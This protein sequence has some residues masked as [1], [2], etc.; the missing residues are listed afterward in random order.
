MADSD[1]ELDDYYPDDDDDMVGLSFDETDGTD[2]SPVSSF[3]HSAKDGII[4]NVTDFDNIADTAKN[5]LP[6]EYSGALSDLQDATD[7]VK[8]LYDTVNKSMEPLADQLA[9]KAE[10]FLP[11]IEK[12]VPEALQ[13][14]IKARAEEGRNRKS[15]ASMEGSADQLAIDSALNEIFQNQAESAA[16]SA[17]VTT[18]ATEEQVKEAKLGRLETANLMGFTNELLGRI[19]GYQDNVTNKFQRKSM[20]LKYKH[21]HA[22]RDLLEVSKVSFG[23]IETRLDAIAKNTALPD[24]LKITLSESNSQ[25]MRDRL[26]G[27]IQGTIS[28]QMSGFTGKL[29]EAAINKVKSTVESARESVSGL[30]DMTEM[31]DMGDMGDMGGNMRSEM[32]G[33]VA[34]GAI[35]DYGRDWLSN[36]VRGV[37]ESGEGSELDRLKS[38]LVSLE[39]E[40]VAAETKEDSSI[41]ETMPLKAEIVRLKAAIAVREKTSGASRNILGFGRRLQDFS[42]NRDT[43]IL[44][45]ITDLT[46]GAD[47]ELE[48]LQQKREEM[49]MERSLGFS[50]YSFKDLAKLDIQIAKLKAKKAAA[51][52]ISDAVPTIGQA[53]NISTFSTENMME[54]MPYTRRTDDTINVVIPGL[55][56]RSLQ[57]LQMIRTG[58]SVDLTTFDRET[59]EFTTVGAMAD[60]VRE[61]TIGNTRERVMAQTDEIESVLKGTG[62]NLSDKAMAALKE[63]VLFD[64]SK[65]RVFNIDR[66][67]SNENALDRVGDQDTATEIREALAGK[68]GDIANDDL[69]ALS[70]KQK[71][72]NS[73]RKIRQELPNFRDEVMLRSRYMDPEVLQRAGMLRTDSDQGVYGQAAN[74]ENLLLSLLG[75]G[76]HDTGPSDQDVGPIMPG[77]GGGPQPF[78]PTPNVSPDNTGVRSSTG[79]TSVSELL[80]DRA[81]FTQTGYQEVERL[82]GEISVKLGGNSLSTELI[83][84]Y[85]DLIASEIYTVAKDATLRELSASALNVPMGEPEPRPD[86]KAR[87]DGISA[88]RATAARKLTDGYSNLMANQ[89]VVDFKDSVKTKFD[90]AVSSVKETMQG[91]HAQEVK[92]KAESVYADISNRAKAGY[93]E[94]TES[95]LIELIRSGDYRA[96]SDLVGDMS[97]GKYEELKANASAKLDDAANYVNRFKTDNG[98]DLTAMRAE[99][100]D[101]ATSARDKAGNWLNSAND[102]LMGKLSEEQRTKVDSLGNAISDGARNAMS[103]ITDMVPD[104][105]FS[106][107]SEGL[108]LRDLDLLEKEY[109]WL[110]DNIDAARDY[111]SNRIPERDKGNPLSRVSEMASN[112]MASLKAKVAGLGGDREGGSVSAMLSGIQQ[113][114]ANVF[115]GLTAATSTSGDRLTDIY[116]GNERDPR[117]TVNGFRRGEYYDQET[118]APVTSPND[119][120][121]VVVDRFGN[122]VLSANDMTEGISDVPGNKP[123]GWFGHTVDLVAR[124]GK[125]IVGGYA[126]L[127]GGTMK[128][129]GGIIGGGEFIGNQ[130]SGLSSTKVDVY[131]PGSETPVLIGNRFGKG[132]YFD[133]ATGKEIGSIRDIL[134]GVL[135]QNGETLI[136]AEDVAEGRLLGRNGKPLELNPQS[137]LG[138]GMGMLGSLAGMYAGGIGAIAGFALRTTKDIIQRLDGVKDVYVQGE[139]K[140]RLRATFMKQGMYYDSET[141]NPIRSIAD[142]GNGVLDSEGNIV[143]SREDIALGLVDV[144]GNELKSI[145]ASAGDLISKGFDLAKRAG[146]GVIDLYGNMFT[147]ISNFIGG[148]KDGAGWHGFSLLGGL[149]QDTQILTEIRDILDQRLAVPGSNDP[150]FNDDNGDGLRD[151]SWQAKLAARREAEATDSAGESEKAKGKS[152]ETGGLFGMLGGAGGML[153]ALKD[154]F[155]PGADTALDAA[156]AAGD[157]ANRGGRAGRVASAAS[158]GGMLSKLGGFAKGALSLGGR[159]AAAGSMS[160]LS[161]AGSMLATAA[162]TVAT[163]ATAVVSA[164]VLLGGLAV[165][166]VGLAAYY[167]YKKLWNTPKGEL[168][169]VRLA[170]YGISPDNKGQ[171]SD[172]TAMEQL[173]LEKTDLGADPIV[174]SDEVELEKVMEAQGVDLA[175]QQQVDTWLNWFQKRFKPV[176]LTWLTVNRQLA[177]GVKLHDLDD[178]DDTLRVKILNSVKFAPGESDPYIYRMAPWPD[179]EQLPMGRLEVQSVFDAAIK[180]IGEVKGDTKGIKVTPG[181]PQNSMDKVDPVTA[182]VDPEAPPAKQNPVGM[183]IN[184]ANADSGIGGKESMAGSVDVLKLPKDPATKLRLAGYGLKEATDAQRSAIA[185]LE[186]AVANDMVFDE[187]SGIAMNR[188]DPNTYFDQYKDAFGVT[189]VRRHEWVDWFRGRF[190]PVFSEYAS[191]AKRNH[192]VGPI[193]AEAKLSD[194]TKAALALK[195]MNSDIR[196]GNALWTNTSSPW[197]DVVTPASFKDV[198]TIQADLKGTK[199]PTESSGPSLQPV[200]A[201]TPEEYAPSIS[202]GT[203]GPD[204]RNTVSMDD[205]FQTGNTEIAPSRRLQSEMAANAAVR[206][207]EGNIKLDGVTAILEKSYQVQSKMASSLDAIS[208]DI[209]HLAKSAGNSLS[210]SSTEKPKAKPSAPSAP[211]RKDAKPKPAPEPVVSMAR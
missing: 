24:F 35:A 163:A 36:T 78:T 51:G 93:Q 67:I 44:D 74:S 168:H 118:G 43:M 46:S 103:A 66:M 75:G 25:M 165:A 100:G 157:L 145:G 20:E 62:I 21:F 191:M 30:L 1:I 169:R 76:K 162:S 170:Q 38:R 141:G 2:R 143:L 199:L 135:D 155:M 99:A 19:V 60:R 204:T 202:G 197:P 54:Q 57:E 152:N 6:S 109:P 10:N 175:N 106:D 136:T 131:L 188:Q 117:L 172:L 108:T 185:N 156:E 189:D 182:P 160:L 142:I 111:L 110:Q 211:K 112:T 56:S 107:L 5:A 32:A 139:D 64:A 94:F 147:G 180:E 59:N 31:M 125:S 8:S 37:I 183:V 70:A 18:A 15:R 29:K 126:S 113:T 208:K 34:G 91:E 184:T 17:A 81:S 88:Y 13:G 16:H 146:K 151:G 102:K 124:T 53:D 203:A 134:T 47:D 50:D 127:I 121:G 195:L 201:A 12:Y 80:G 209:K 92:A 52:F 27:D 41:V 65:G 116:V 73:G 181:Q 133:P 90:S 205:K 95:E 22:A 187:G 129:A 148:G 48:Q 178:Q 97:K 3:V 58:E 166:A 7:T 159:V 45:T 164:P 128:A 26:L 87:W 123:S 14:A 132:F 63:Q 150:A 68:F 86:L 192:S 200:K 115:D 9:A 140:P 193:G 105:L 4:E 114:G 42:D 77:L 69:E 144:N 11:K 84:E 104:N 130:L 39:E 40:L 33:S 190:L 206:A 89:Q 161:G 137:L 210:S 171:L 176:F 101:L 167:A 79:D 149:G 82:L 49:A 55:L 85:L 119:I 179:T 61:D 72:R 122:I 98:Y 158:R 186:Q 153:G 138:K 96:A 196:N 154:R 71:L 28:E 177:P 83:E 23:N 173:F 174:L 207:S 120:A 194:E 198:A